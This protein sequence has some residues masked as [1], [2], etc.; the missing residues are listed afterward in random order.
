MVPMPLFHPL[1]AKILTLELS[2][3]VGD[4]YRFVSDSSRASE[5]TARAKARAKAKGKEKAKAKAYALA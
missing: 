4:C 1:K 2:M 3:K 5:T